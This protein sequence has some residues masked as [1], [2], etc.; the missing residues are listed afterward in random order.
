MERRRP[1]L[2]MADDATA[3]DAR[4][5]ATKVPLIPDL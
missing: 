2:V 1:F 4:P 3:L 5:E